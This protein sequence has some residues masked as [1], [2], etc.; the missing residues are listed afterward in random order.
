MNKEANEV[1]Q[2]I[3]KKVVVII[4]ITVIFFNYL[5]PI[6]SPFIVGLLLSYMLIPLTNL[7]ENCKIP[8]P[9]GYFVSLCFL[10]LTLSSLIYFISESLFYQMSKLIENSPY[11]INEFSNVLNNFTDNLDSIFIDLPPMLSETLYK[12][13]GNMLDSIISIVTSINYTPLIS[14]VPKFFIN[15]LIALFTSYFFTVDKNLWKSIQNNY[16]SPLFADY[17]SNS[18]NDILNSL[19]GYIKT[20]GILMIYIW[21]LCTI[22]LTILKS[23]YS[24]AL[25]ISIAIIDALPVFG[26]GFFLWPISLYYLLSGNFSLA[27]GYFILYIVLQIVR[28][29]MQPKI[30]GD[31]INLHPLLALFSMCL[32]YEAIGFLGLIVAPIVTI[33]LKNI[34]STQNN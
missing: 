14:G 28:Q 20:Q 13:Q 31:Q 1:T 27:L 17:F 5:L 11:Y 12:I 2:S 18:K 22:G 10:L 8:R 4:F 33:L 3:V 6:L 19:F 15:T 34:C 23:E 7:F 21:I 9:L 16:I 24:F 32:G 29:I 30:L 26:S 25:G